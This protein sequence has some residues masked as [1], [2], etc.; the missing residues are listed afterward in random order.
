MY[1]LVHTNRLIRWKLISFG[2]TASSAEREFYD[3]V[4]VNKQSEIN[5]TLAKSV[6]A[7]KLESKI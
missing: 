2:F 3:N 6:G 1:A 5:C 7:V 4:T